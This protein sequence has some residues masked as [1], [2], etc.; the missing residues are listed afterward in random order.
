MNSR[1]LRIALYSPGIVGLGHLR[2]NLLISQSLAHSPLQPVNLIL[3]EAREAT[4][5]VNA[6]LP[7]MD[8]VTLPGLRKD[9]DGA[10]QA[11]HLDLSFEEMVQL[12][13]KTLAAVLEAFSP[14]V[15]I[16]DH[17][18][19]GAGGELD[20]AL[21]VLRPKATTR[22]VLGLRDVLGEPEVVNSDWLRWR[23]EAAIRDY[24][25]AIWVYGDRQVYDLP[26]QCR[27]PEDIASKIRFTGY[28]DQRP[29][30]AALA[31]DPHDPLEALGLP[32]GRLVL[33][34][35]GG[36]QD[37]DRLA[38][39]FVQA[40]LPPGC[41]GVLVA[42][43]FMSADVVQDLSRQA[44]LQ[45]RLRV[46]R[47]I[48]EPTLILRRAERVIAMG[49]YNTICEVLSFEKPALIVP[50][51]WPRREQI[52]RAERLR[53]LG[54]I[55]MLHP[56]ALTPQALSAWMARDIAPPQ[57]KGRINFNGLGRV[58]ELV[59]ELLAPSPDHAH[60]PQCAAA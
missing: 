60:E 30:L 14:D 6:M 23:N 59:T 47:F 45:S 36:G 4:A 34:L 48:P 19:R 24:Y 38:R 52:I 50:R 2:R 28:L 40:E 55:D 16:V 44:A 9:A 1:K 37:G 58:P 57:A 20:L 11:R 53:D 51:A 7:G 8:C 13:S 22:C 43:P 35:V 31:A 49:G 5:Y 21:Q 17:L 27:F 56:E 42:G 3:A 29:R 33:C 32:E 15:L 41:N 39:T 26:T 46:L 54:F 18:P 10:C 25:A 12:R